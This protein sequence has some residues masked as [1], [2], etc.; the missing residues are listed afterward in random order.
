MGV[1]PT[2]SPLRRATDWM[3]TDRATGRYVIGQFPNLALWLFL[4][5]TLVGLVLRPQG[6]AAATALRLVSAT[7]LVWWAIDEVIR[8]VNPFRR[9]LGGGVLVWTVG[10]LIGWVVNSTG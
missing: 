4:A 7:A 1:T 3:F 9:V 8:G 6:G 2:R 5:A 10:G